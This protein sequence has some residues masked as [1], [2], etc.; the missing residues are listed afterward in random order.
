MRYRERITL[1]VRNEEPDKKRRFMA[2]NGF[3]RVSK[4]YR[5]TL[6][7]QDAPRRASGTR[8]TSAAYLETTPSEFFEVPRSPPQADWRGGFVR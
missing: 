1:E 6:P 2:A 7:G 3:V 4:S 8:K 5:T